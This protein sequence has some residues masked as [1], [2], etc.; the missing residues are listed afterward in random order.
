MAEETV[1]PPARACMGILTTLALAATL[2]AA[3]IAVPK[4]VDDNAWG[5]TGPTAAKR[6]GRLASAT[7]TDAHVL[8][9]RGGVEA[10]HT[11]NP[12]AAVSE[13]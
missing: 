3:V 9:R 8:R 1:S 6:R 11:D 10:A 7:S 5:A 4:H 2:V 12:L 13:F